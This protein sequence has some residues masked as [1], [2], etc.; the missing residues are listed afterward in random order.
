V[1]ILH[2]S[3]CVPAVGAL[4]VATLGVGPAAA[5]EGTQFREV[6]TG[7]VGMIATES[8][9]ATEVGLAILEQGGSAV[10]AAIATVLAINVARPQSCGIGGGGFMVHRAADGALAALD[11]REEAPS[12]FTS[13]TLAGPGI[14]QGFSGHLVVGVPGTVAGLWAAHQRY[15][16]ME[17]ADLVAPA[18]AMARD[19]VIVQQ[20]LSE[21][22][23]T[24]A[25]RLR[26]FESAAEQFLVG[27]VSP[28]PAGSTLVQTDLAD[29]LVTLGA[30]GRDAFYSGPI[31]EA[32][33]AEMVDNAGAY[34]GDEGLL[35]AEDLLAYEAIWRDPLVGE[36][37]GAQIV[38]MPPPTSGGI[39]LL[40]ILN[41]LSGFD[42]QT[43][44]HGS[45]DHIHLLAEAQ[46]MA[47]ADRNAYVG[48]PDVVD[49][50]TE[51]LTSMAY[52][53]SR[54]GE[55]S[56]VQARGYEPATI[57][58][59]SVLPPGADFN[60]LGST[61]NLSVM[62]AEGNALALT[63]T[64]EQGFGSG[65]VATGAGFLLNNELTDFSGAGTANE[66]GPGKRPRSS[67]SP[68]IV[69]IDSQPTLA[70][71]GAGG[72]TIIMGS[73]HAVLNV[74]A[75]GMDTAQAID[76][77]RWD[78]SSNPTLNIENDRVSSE[79]Q[80]QLL[81]RGHRI[82]SQGEYWILPRVQG[83]GVNPTSGVHEA[84]SDSRTDFAAAAQG[85]TFTPDP[86]P[87]AEGD[88]SSDGS[89]DTDGGGLAAT[90]GGAL[91]MLGATLGLCAIMLTRRR[92]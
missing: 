27:G 45:A 85:G 82:V 87:V 57:S 31:G 4:L 83:V 6:I 50:P 7:D 86:I 20:S 48:D 69:V 62:D 40:E 72:A 18:E 81:Q 79:V 35:T 91:A 70:V 76:A 77:Q 56:L 66:P 64:I 13:S 61:T 28:Y 43:D 33:V 84:A 23:G 54:R 58:G 10:D 80:A 25:P 74:V 90:G 68:T 51:L 89:S 17:W 53:D 14:N 16:T 78:S 1:G 24:A 37:L 42:I 60:P 88:S 12:A 22:M 55:I 3:I 15:G 47:W 59:A 41:L 73:V 26:L 9:A 32:I 49:V 21:A 46:K 65:V 5:T 8:P 39:A 63:C 19:G 29:T 67:I 75:F 11:F 38:A 52:A 92:R 71:G 30:G 34:P 44:G 36:Y 2:R